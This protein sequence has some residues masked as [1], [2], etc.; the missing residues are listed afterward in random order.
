MLLKKINEIYIKNKSLE[1]KFNESEDNLDHNSGLLN[2]NLFFLIAVSLLNLLMIFISSNFVFI[3][4]LF[5][6]LSSSL[7]FYMKKRHCKKDMKLLVNEISKG[8]KEFDDIFYA[9]FEIISRDLLSLKEKNEE[10][11]I[12]NDLIE[13]IIDRKLDQNKSLDKNFLFKKSFVNNLEV[14][15]D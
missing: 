13:I 4:A 14:N 3:T 2:L 6:F 12:S 15:N 1:I 10:N 9:H 11:K 7:F 8:K 5:L